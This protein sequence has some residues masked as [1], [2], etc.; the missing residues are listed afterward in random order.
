MR[1]TGKRAHTRVSGKRHTK[2]PTRQPLS[3]KEGEKERC[4]IQVGRTEIR[5]KNASRRVLAEGIHYTRAR[6]AYPRYVYMAR[7]MEG[8]P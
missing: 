8:V 7:G 2:Q 4:G 5:I 1:V 6:A 3:H